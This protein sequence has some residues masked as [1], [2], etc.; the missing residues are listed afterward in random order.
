MPALCEMVI[1]YI[2]ILSKYTTI[3]IP[4]GNTNIICLTK[5][6][7]NIVIVTPCSISLAIRQSPYTKGHLTQYRKPLRFKGWH[8]LIYQT[9]KLYFSLGGVVGILG[10][11][12]VWAASRYDHIPP[13]YLYPLF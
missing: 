1:H 3:K 8:I 2:S 5:N 12:P 9:L 13:L 4:H 10:C 6:S 7:L 11:D